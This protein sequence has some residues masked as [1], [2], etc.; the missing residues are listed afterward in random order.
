MIRSLLNGRYA[1]TAFC[2][3]DPQGKRRLS[4][5]GRSPTQVMGR[6]GSDSNDS[7]IEEMNRVASQYRTK[8]SDKDTTLQDFLSFRQAL[9]VASADQ[10]L[11]VFVNADKA[12]VK[13]LDPILRELFADEEIAGRFHLDFAGKEDARWRKSIEGAKSKPAINIIRAGKF[14]T[15]GAIM[16][17]LPLSS[18]LDE[19]E[20]NAV[21]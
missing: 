18:S 20:S 4:R 21:G 9:N 5:T 2:I 8:G 6:R 7:I 1:N 11:L 13:K 12:A 19:L 14:G 17:S 3:F 16:S 10:R 15:D